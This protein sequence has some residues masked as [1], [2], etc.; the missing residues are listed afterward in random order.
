L[1]DL[2]T[3][4]DPGILRA[5]GGDAKA[6]STIHWQILAAFLLGFIGPVVALGLTNRLRPEANELVRFLVWIPLVA[7][8]L[9]LIR[10]TR[11]PVY[12]SI[13][14]ATNEKRNKKRDPPGG[15]QG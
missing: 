8:I 13:L 10:V 9:L 5:A 1:R 14:D 6:L 15:G 12:R 4:E 3:K 11:S 7:A 2:F